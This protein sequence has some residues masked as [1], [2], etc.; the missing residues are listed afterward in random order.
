M[1]EPIDIEVYSRPG[2][3]LCHEAVAVIEPFSR[4]FPLKI[5]ITDVDSEPSLREA[6]GMEIPVILING[7][8]AFRHRVDPSALERRLKE[9][10]NKSIS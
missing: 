9:L 6:F 1:P 10:W 7:K 4:H 3:H 2:C 5:R 8:E